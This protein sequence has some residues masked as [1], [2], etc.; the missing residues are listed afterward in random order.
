MQEVWLP[1][2]SVTVK[3]TIELLQRIVPG[4]ML[5]ET[6]KTPL[7]SVACTRLMA[8]GIRPQPFVEHTTMLV[9]QTVIFGRL[10]ST[11]VTVWLQVF[12]LPEQSAASQVR[13]M[14]C[15][16]IPLVTVPKMLRVTLAPLQASTA[17][18]G[19]KNQ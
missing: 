1:Q 12:V 6:W 2:S 13:V 16:Q 3:V 19:A 5:C 18:G 10:V 9:G 14:T 11:T 15:G 17:V 4:A 7:L 8:L